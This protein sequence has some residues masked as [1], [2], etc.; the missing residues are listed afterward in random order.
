MSD[1]KPCPFCGSTDIAANSFAIEASVRC[2]DCFAVLVRKH[3]RNTD[4]GLA[5]VIEAWNTRADLS[6]ALLRE[7]ME[8]LGGVMTACDQGRM[9]AKTGVGG[10]TIEANIRGSVYMG[11]PAW[12][13]E[14]ARATLDKLRAHFGE[15]K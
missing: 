12:P 10:M 13:I 9:V 3:P 7:A 8:A 4:G 5:A 1:L 14:I 11:V 2:F 6:D 15:D